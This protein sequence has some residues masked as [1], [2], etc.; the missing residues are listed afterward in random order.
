MLKLCQWSLGVLLIA[1]LAGCGRESFYT[2]ARP[3]N[4]EMAPRLYLSNYDHAFVIALHAVE[5][6]PKWKLQYFDKNSGMIQA[7]TNSGDLLTVRVHPLDRSAVKIFA[8][9]DS[10]GFSLLGGGRLKENVL[11]Y[12][13]NLDS[14]LKGFDE[15]ILQ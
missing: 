13:D 1:I 11:R 14:H 2:M 15:E 4:P 6:E 7:Q 9:C 12:F 3:K 8:F 10:K 5:L